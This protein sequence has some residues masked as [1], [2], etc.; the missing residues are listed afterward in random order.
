MLYGYN[1]FWGWLDVADLA[2]ARLCPLRGS[3]FLTANLNHQPDRYAGAGLTAWMKTHLTGA[4]SWPQA[5]QL[6]VQSAGT[7]QLLVLIKP[8]QAS[9][10]VQE[11]RLNWSFADFCLVAPP[12]RFWHSQSLPASSPEVKIPLPDP[13]LAV[14]FYADIIYHDQTKIS[15]PLTRVSPLALGCT[16]PASDLSYYLE[17]HNF[18]W[19]C[20]NTRTEP[21]DPEDEFWLMTGPDGQ[22]ALAVAEAGSFS[23]STNKFTDPAW[24]NS[25]CRDRLSLVCFASVPGSWEL[26]VRFRPDQAGERIWSC[27]R[28]F[29]GWQDLDLAADDFL[30]SQGKPLPCWSFLQRLTVTFL[31]KDTGW[32]DYSA[33]LGQAGWF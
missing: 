14:F 29:S 28:D 21:F 3:S 7:G 33:A 8:G 16:H 4:D 27:R 2:M 15:S 22:K 24:Q 25:G 12:A 11:V 32:G 10:T 9:K 26:Q 5:P 19:H 1:D 18:G 23:F 31:P 30:S 6:Q 13:E 17:P 20:T